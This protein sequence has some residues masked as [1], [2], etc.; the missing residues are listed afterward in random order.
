MATSHTEKLNAFARQQGYRNYYELRKA[1]AQAQGYR[2]LTEQRKARKTGQGLRGTDAENPRYRREPV[3]A[4]APRRYTPP[5]RIERVPSLDER[6]SEAAAER[7][8]RL[9]PKAQTDRV[10]SS[11][12]MREQMLKDR[13]S[14]VLSNPKYETQGKRY[15]EHRE[16][17]EALSQRMGKDS[18]EFFDLRS[19]PLGRIY[20]D[21][22]LAAN[23]N[24]QLGPTDAQLLQKISTRGQ[25]DLVT[26]A[27]FAKHDSRRFMNDVKN[28]RE[29][30]PLLG[31]KEFPD[32]PGVRAKIYADG[33]RH[34]LGSYAELSM[35]AAAQRA[36]VLAVANAS[37]VEW[38]SITDGTD[39]GWHSHDDPDKA[40]GSVR[41]LEEVLA[42][43]IAHP[44]CSRTIQPIYEAGPKGKG[45]RASE[46]LGQALKA[47][48]GYLAVDM[49]S[50]GVKALLLNKNVQ[51]RVASIAARAVPGGW[52]HRVNNFLKTQKSTELPEGVADLNAARLSKAVAEQAI[53]DA[54]YDLA[55]G[56]AA[57]RRLRG[58]LNIETEALPKAVG[59]QFDQYIEYHDRTVRA[60]LSLREA[61]ELGQLEEFAYQA[62]GEY[63]G[64]V[65][66]K[67][68]RFTFPKIGNIDKQTGARFAFEPN[69]LINATVT[70]T[71]RGIVNHLGFNRHGLFRAGVSRDPE[72]GLWS[73]T[74]RAVP[75]GPIRVMAKVNR[76]KGRKLVIEN[77]GPGRGGRLGNIVQEGKF[78]EI[79]Q[80]STDEL[81]QL[82]SLNTGDTLRLGEY[83]YEK[84][85]P[86]EVLQGR[87]RV[88]SV[89]WEAKLV[90]KAPV[91]FSAAFNMNLRKLGIHSW[92]D[93]RDMDLDDFRKLSPRDLKFVSAAAEVRAGPPIGPFQ[94]AKTFRITPDRA[95]E[96]WE[97]TNQWL[98]NAIANPTQ[99]PEK[100]MEGIQANIAD[101]V[102][103]RRREKFVQV[104][105]DAEWEKKIRDERLKAIRP[106]I[107]K[108]KFFTPQTRKEY[109]GSEVVNLLTGETG[110]VITTGPA[111]VHVQYEGRLVKY[112]WETVNERTRILKQEEE[113]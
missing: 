107:D 63:F 49:A 54:Q 91:N 45:R 113:E 79:V 32:P 20:Q 53:A 18:I 24:Y 25:K 39:C 86:D 109:P 8:R 48:A 15:V 33:Q 108:E 105:G 3:R 38:F 52:L 90:T 16:E 94:L 93:I 89:S 6:R 69:K 72:T 111:Y 37:G 46:V 60:K 70:R 78:Q 4:P 2:N 102:A 101:T 55:E 27:T 23:P 1:R 83:I 42:Y 95:Q 104:F 84:V 22:A 7:L 26:A 30:N 71:Q 88:T 31:E 73:P 68:A 67:V 9:D 17:M 62:A 13:Q 77:L 99:F 19:G 80:L 76:S 110:E 100:I 51:A 43:P 96:L 103:R 81:F 41:S 64:S 35:R 56:A 59:D 85:G 14:R 66:T 87:G 5:P 92:Q 11:V 61:V 57:S 34:S 40:H 106:R 29:P 44:N 28:R 21:A 112:P 98:E 97:L 74:F 36:H 65:G 47:Q 50:E 82:N 10:V 75:K 12:K 58:F